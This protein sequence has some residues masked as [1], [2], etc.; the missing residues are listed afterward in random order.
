[1]PGLPQ[2]L[3]FPRAHSQTIDGLRT[4]VQDGFKGI[5]RWVQTAAQIINAQTKTD[6]L[7]NRTANPVDE[8]FFVASDT[9]QAFTAVSGVWKNVAPR[10]ARTTVASGAASLTASFIG[11]SHAS[12][13]P[14]ALPNWE[15]TVFVGSIDASQVSFDFG[16][17]PANGGTLY[18]GIFDEW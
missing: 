15:T 12:L 10:R 2:Q 17:A 16:T 14:W 8:A 9:Q 4:Q 13:V 3:H 7:N 5:A 18:W 1:M 6:T 11:G